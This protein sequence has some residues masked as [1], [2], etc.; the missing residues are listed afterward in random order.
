MKEELKALKG[1]AE[2]LVKVRKNLS[3]QKSFF[4]MKVEEKK[5]ETGI[6]EIIDL[7]DSYE[8]AKMICFEFPIIE[9]PIYDK[10][11]KIRKEHPKYGNRRIKELIINDILN[12]KE[13][14]SNLY[15]PLREGLEI[16]IDNYFLY[17]TCGFF[18]IYKQE[19]EIIE[20]EKEARVAADVILD[21]TKTAAIKA[22]ETV[23]N[24]VKPYGDVAKSQLNDVGVIAK[25]FVNKGS[26]KLK[27][28]FE[29][30]E[31]KNK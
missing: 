2:Q 27:K 21:E 1:S 22:G 26:Q 14:N 17:E 13:L 19:T 9:Y 30:L 7:S 25:K 6:E 24:V 20:L 11:S 3:K 4:N 31:E 29:T 16:I 23:V 28:I 10:V 18:K 12:N 15:P 8:S 5:Q